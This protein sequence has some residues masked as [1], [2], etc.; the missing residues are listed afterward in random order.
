MSAAER[1][2]DDGPWLERLVLSTPVGEW[3]TF[4]LIFSL[5]WLSVMSGLSASFLYDDWALSQRGQLVQAQVIRAN[6]DQRGPTFNAELQAPFEGTRVI[7]EDIKQRPAAGTV[8]VLEVDPEKPTRVRDPQAGRWSLWDVGFI[9]LVPVG[10]VVAWARG[11]RWL[12]GRRR[13]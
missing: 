10:L 13:R 11:N 9:A 1:S 6:Y 4:G 12:R 2:R 8:A 7:V 5:V 3:S